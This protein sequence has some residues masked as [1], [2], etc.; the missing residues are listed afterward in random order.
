[1]TASTAPSGAPGSA[2]RE[3][4][5]RPIFTY[6]VSGWAAILAWCAAALVLVAAAIT[7]LLS[8]R[9]DDWGAE[10]VSILGGLG[11]APRVFA[12][13]IGLGLI[14]DLRLMVVFGRTRRAYARQALLFTAASSAAVALLYVLLAVAEAQL[15]QLF[16]WEPDRTA[17]EVF[18]LLPSLWPTLWVWT[19]IGVIGAALAY[20]RGTLGVVA[21]M[22]GAAIAVAVAELALGSMSGVLAGLLDLAGPFGLTEPS[23]AV[24]ILV[25]AAVAALLAALARPLMHTLPVLPD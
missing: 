23:A 5:G 13:I 15:Y 22:A 1:M 11:W 24:S 16:G 8:W 21:A 10:P 12:L 3:P 18:A 25:P 14:A 7:L 4:S 6:L 2:A 19:A 17:V 9:V 20:T